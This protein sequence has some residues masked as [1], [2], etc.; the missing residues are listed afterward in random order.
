[1][2]TRGDEQNEVTFRIATPP[3]FAALAYEGSAEDGNDALV[4]QEMEQSPRQ[5]TCAHKQENMNDH[6]VDLINVLHVGIAPLPANIKQ[7]NEQDRISFSTLSSGSQEPR[8]KSNSLGNSAAET[9]NEL[10][11]ADVHPTPSAHGPSSNSTHP[12]PASSASDTNQSTQQPKP[13]IVIVLSESDKDDDP[14]PWQNQSDHT[15]AIGLRTPPKEQLQAHDGRDVDVLQLARQARAAL[16]LRNKQQPKPNQMETKPP[17]S[18]QQNVLGHRQ[19]T[20]AGDSD[21]AGRSC[22]RKGT[23]EAHPIISKAMSTEGK[24]A[25]SQSERSSKRSSSA[26]GASD[27]PDSPNPSPLG[28]TLVGRTLRE[29]SMMRQNEEEGAG[30]GSVGAENEGINKR[31]L[32]DTFVMSRQNSLNKLLSTSRSRS[33]HG[34]DSPFLFNDTFNM[35]LSKIFLQQEM[36]H[37]EPASPLMADSRDSSLST[38]QRSD[39]AD[40]FRHYKRSLQELQAQKIRDSFL[41]AERMRRRAIEAAEERTLVAGIVTPAL[42]ERSQIIFNITRLMI[43]Q[44]QTAAAALTE[45]DKQKQFL[46]SKSKRRYSPLDARSRDDIEFDDLFSPAN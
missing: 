15:D 34:R 45:A 44:Q 20:A 23:Q 46:I 16:E 17:K 6:E 26:A 19:C 13:K 8:V 5:P 2:T 21:A 36:L 11:V 22:D 35:T 39:H 1:M 31:K 43:E 41:V 4:H 32:N 40:L 42:H 3:S 37:N 12:T 7:I 27:N 10:S 25:G 30:T 28:M 9:K 38:T 33:D 29:L 14:V 18:M 24:H